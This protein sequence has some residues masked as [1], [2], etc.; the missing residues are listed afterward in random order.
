MKGQLDMIRCT[1]A[2]LVLILAAWPG[3]AC[4]EP[5]AELPEGPARAVGLESDLAVFGSGRVLIVADLSEPSEPV[6]LGRVVLTGVVRG[7]DVVED[8]AYAA[9]GES[10][11]AIID[12]SDLSAPFILGAVAAEF[13][14][15]IDVVVGESH[16]Y[17]VEIAHVTR[18]RNPTYL[19]VIDVSQPSQP[20]SVGS[21]EEPLRVATKLAVSGDVVFLTTYPHLWPAPTGYAISVYD[22]SACGVSTTRRSTGRVTP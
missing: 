13:G 11:L 19:N 18:Y 17:T 3:V 4:L 8:R 14:E 6:E 7:I 16:V 12:L 22:L 9:M 10:G 15:T 1:L 21:I 2:T 20:V 5:V